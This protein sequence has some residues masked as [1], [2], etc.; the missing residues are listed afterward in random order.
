MDT[1]FLGVMSSV[2]T[3]SGEVCMECVC[4][5]VTHSDSCRGPWIKAEVAGGVTQ[6]PGPLSMACLCLTLPDALAFVFHCDWDLAKQ[7]MSDRKLFQCKWLMFHSGMLWAW[8]F[9]VVCMLLEHLLVL[10]ILGIAAGFSISGHAKFT[11]KCNLFFYCLAWNQTVFL[12]SVT[13]FIASVLQVCIFKKACMNQW[14]GFSWE[15]RTSFLCL[16]WC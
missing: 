14:L 13:K 8:I 12:V 7:D 3:E 11:L 16:P 2:V 10:G 9:R 5:G 4:G 1:L 6:W 15:L